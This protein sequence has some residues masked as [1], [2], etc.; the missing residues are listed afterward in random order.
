MT[1]I[2]EF[3][4][5]YPFKPY[6]RAYLRGDNDSVMKE[7]EIISYPYEDEGFG[8]GTAWVKIRTV[9]GDPDTL[10]T[11]GCDNLIRV[12]KKVRCNKHKEP[13]VPKAHRSSAYVE[14]KDVMTVTLDC[15]HCFRGY[16]YVTDKMKAE[17]HEGQ[18]GEWYSDRPLEILE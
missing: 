5:L 2:L 4:K 7:V 16:S 1:T 17:G 8:K 9:P 10:A 15:P 3:R 11:T 13:F 18:I 6:D 12:P 14:D